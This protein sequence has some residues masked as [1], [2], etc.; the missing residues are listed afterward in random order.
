MTRH[1][2]TTLIVAVQCASVSPPRHSE[3]KEYVQLNWGHYEEPIG[4]YGILETTDERTWPS[5]F[6]NPTFD[7]STI[8]D[9]FNNLALHQKQQAAVE[10]ATFP[11]GGEAFGEDRRLEGR[12]VRITGLQRRRKQLTQPRRWKE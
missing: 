1:H 12:E 10:L 2:T 3:E 9:S 5:P 11:L 4:P 8:V 7:P 6:D